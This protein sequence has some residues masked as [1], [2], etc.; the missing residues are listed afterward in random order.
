VTLDRR[1]GAVNVGNGLA[2]C[3]LSNE[4]F[5]ILGERNYRGGS[6]ET[7]SVSDNGGLAT[8]EYGDDRVGRSEVNAYCT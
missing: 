1:N 2:L 6:A 5:A 4:Y 3:G 7:F 8:F